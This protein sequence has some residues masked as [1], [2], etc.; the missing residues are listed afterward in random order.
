[1]DFDE[2]QISKIRRISWRIVPKEQ[3]YQGREDLRNIKKQDKSRH[4]KEEIRE[5]FR[6]TKRKKC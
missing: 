1:M 6:A 3:R 5:D 4:S 2:E